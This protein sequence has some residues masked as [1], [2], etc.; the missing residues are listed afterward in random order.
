MV[1]IDPENGG[2][3][4]WVWRNTPLLPEP[5]TVVAPPPKMGN[6]LH[7]VAR[8]RERVRNFEA[9]HDIRP[10]VRVKALASILL[11][12]GKKPNPRK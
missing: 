2:G 8:I 4:P 6:R 12:C 10:N 7:L 5:T 11:P 9:R 1:D 3:T